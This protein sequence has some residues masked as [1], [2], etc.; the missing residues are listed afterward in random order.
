MTTSTTGLE[1][2]LSSMSLQPGYTTPSKA[3]A[4]GKPLT[5]RVLSSG[6]QQ[7]VSR[8]INNLK[9]AN[10]KVA[11]AD[12]KIARAQAD[13][14]AAKREIEE[15]RRLQ[16]EGRRL[17]QEGRAESE[18]ARAN[19]AAIDTQ[20]VKN[21]EQ[22]AAFLEAKKGQHPSAASIQKIDTL[23]NKILHYK[24]NLPATGAART[25]QMQAF[26]QEAILLLQTLNASAS[27]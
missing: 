3:P 1:G 12:Q 21:L 14:A 9:A 19:L 4:Q 26:K 7:E 22:I 8:R 25:Q 2:A 6:E 17:Q 23:R 18:Q 27:K 16:Q 24:D 20:V 13:Q 10:S 15:G 11:A 5:V